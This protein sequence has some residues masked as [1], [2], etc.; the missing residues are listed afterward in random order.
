MDFAGVG[1]NEGGLFNRD[2]R[3]FDALRRV[4]ESL[5]VKIHVR[6]HEKAVGAEETRIACDR[7]IE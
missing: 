2:S 4:I 7:F 3:E 1:V 5:P 6:G